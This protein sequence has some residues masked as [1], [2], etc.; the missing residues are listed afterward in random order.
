[1]LLSELPPSEY[2][3]FYRTYI[4]ALG[5]VDLFE[6]LKAGRSDFLSLLEKIPEGK[7]HFAYEKGKWTLAESIVHML[8][9]ERIFQYRS[10]C[11]ARNDK[12][13]LPGFDQDDYVPFSNPT[14]R[15]KNDLIEE[16]LAVRGATATLFSSFDEEALKRVGTASGS[17]ISVRAMG[18]IISGHQAHHIRII[19]ERYLS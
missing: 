18:F 13:L 11:I 3:P 19:E 17:K 6:E 8:D 1:M 7:L 4:M 14:N 5:D 16:Y 10:L 15:T 12:T 9:T 2:N